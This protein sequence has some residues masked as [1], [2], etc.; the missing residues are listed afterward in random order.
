MEGWR[1]S[2]YST[3]PMC[4][5]G[6]VLLG[7]RGHGD[8]ATADRAATACGAVPRA[9]PSFHKSQYTRSPGKVYKK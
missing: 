9:P 1:I 2:D 8:G 3:T 6:T 4:M 5:S 7:G